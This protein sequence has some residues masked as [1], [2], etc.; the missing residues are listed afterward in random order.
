MKFSNWPI[1]RK[2]AALIAFVILTTLL[3]AASMLYAKHASMM[4]A[5]REQTRNLVEVA[6]GIVAQS[7]AQEKSGELTREQAQKQS[8][9]LLRKLRYDQNE[10]F[11]INDM[12]PRIVMHPIKPELDGQDMSASADPKGKKLFVAF[13]DEVRRSGAGYVD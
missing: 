2:L 4:L 1:G 10:Y 8:A 3:G 12:Q 5:K 13:V 9:D 7:Y 11:W 6:H